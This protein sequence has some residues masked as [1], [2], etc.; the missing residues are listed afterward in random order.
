VT[1]VGL[2]A[3]LEQ[4]LAGNAAVLVFGA[5]LVAVTVVW[6]GGLSHARGGRVSSLTHRLRPGRKV[7]RTLTER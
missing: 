1:G 7:P 4:R 3:D 5:L 2:P 6:P